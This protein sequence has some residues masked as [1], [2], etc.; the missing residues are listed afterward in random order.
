MNI[1]ISNDMIDRDVFETII[2]PEFIL[3]S[4]CVIVVD[5]SRS[6]EIMESLKKWTN[7]IY[8]TFSSLLL[9]FPFEKQTEMREQCKI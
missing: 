4:M 7:F 6:W 3:K 9:K 8:D 5:L 2:K 1:W